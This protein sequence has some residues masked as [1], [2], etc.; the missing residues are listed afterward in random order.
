MS[1]PLRSSVHP[2]KSSRVLLGA[3]VL[4]VATAKALPE[5]LPRRAVQAYRVVKR[6]EGITPTGLRQAM[7]VNRNI[8]SGAVF[9]LRQKQLIRRVPIVTERRAGSVNH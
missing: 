3:R 1:V 7:R 5:G 4:Y 8:V 6:T 2:V 9:R